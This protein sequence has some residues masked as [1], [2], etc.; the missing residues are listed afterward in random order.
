VIQLTASLTPG[1]H[2]AA[3][4]RRS[5]RKGRE[6]GCSLYVSAEE[7]IGAG[8]DPYASPP[9]YRIWH[10]RKGTLLVQLYPAADG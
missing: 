3:A 4:R 2:D 9:E 8:I 6:R 7:L 5:S 1:R 10:G